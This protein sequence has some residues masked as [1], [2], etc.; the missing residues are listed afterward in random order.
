M[1]DSDPIGLYSYLIG[2]LN[3]RNLGFIE[4]VEGGDE[5]VKDKLCKIWK[6]SFNGTWITNAG[7]TFETGN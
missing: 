2:E 7:Y 3:K 5:T 6:S 1:K 4:M